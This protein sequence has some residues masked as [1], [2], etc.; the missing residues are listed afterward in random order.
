[1]GR[2]GVYL[3]DAAAIVFLLL[4]ISGVWLW[5]RRQASIKTHR[6]KTKMADTGNE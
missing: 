5:A 3:V 2:A 6:R 1:L 4:A